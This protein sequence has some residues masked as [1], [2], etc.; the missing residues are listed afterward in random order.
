ME[1]MIEHVASYLNADP[2]AVRQV[3]LYK[4][5]D[6]TP[7]GQP[8][9]Y[10]NVD[11]LILQLKNTSEYDK[12]R[13][14]VDNFNRENRWKKKG[15]SLTPIKWGVGLNGSNYNCMVSIYAGDGSISVSHG[16][17]EIGQGIHTK[18][19]QVCAYALNVPI[20]IISIKPADNFT[21]PNGAPT[22]GSGTSESVGLA[23]QK[24]C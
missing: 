20:D 4:K 3:N 8:L 22:G 16:G 18:V 5:D 11:Q 6:V 1:M 15:L 21:N 14:D 17:V 23:V 7:N 13:V 2:L 9:P 24:C 19:A 12:R 10:F